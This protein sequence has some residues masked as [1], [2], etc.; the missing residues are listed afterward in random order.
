MRLK[1]AAALLAA[2]AT[3]GCGSGGSDEDKIRD[4]H[5]AFSE[6]VADG[7]GDEA[8]ALMTSEAR[9]EALGAGVFLGGGDCAEVLSKFKGLLDKG[10]LEELRNSKVT[11]VT[12]TGETALVRASSDIDDDDDPTRMRKVSGDW[13]IDA[14]PED[15]EEADE[16]ETTAGEDQPDETEDQPNDDPSTPQTTVAIGQPLRQSDYTI[17]VTGVRRTSTIGGDDEF[18]DPV[19]ADGV[20][21]ILDLRVRNSAKKVVTF[22]NALVELVDADGTVYSSSTGGAEDQIGALAD[23]I[24]EREIQ[25]KSSESGALAFDVPRAADV[26]KAQF[27][28]SVEDFSGR[29]HRGGRAE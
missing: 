28:S 1:V 4:T 10:D 24:D 8:C 29:V 6:A 12:I 7:E 27:A 21:V 14:D 26:V 2:I 17:T 25:P 9:Q 15:D 5:R 3:L 16:T 22:D 23:Y 11:N 13:L 20:F 19:K 18:S